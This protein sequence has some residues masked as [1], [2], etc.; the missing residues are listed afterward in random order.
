V[1]AEP[2][3]RSARRHAVRSE[4]R[5]GDVCGRWHGSRPRATLFVVGKY[6]P[7]RQRLERLS[8]ERVQLTFSEIDRLVGGLPPSAHRHT[9]CGATKDKAAMSRRLRGWIP[10]GA[11]RTS[12]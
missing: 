6:D 9:A 3:A 12:I 1:R 8:P 7:L 4:V 11:S 5:D 10:D 2:V